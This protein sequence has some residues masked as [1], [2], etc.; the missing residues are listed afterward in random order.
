[1]TFYRKHAALF[2]TQGAWNA[3]LL[4]HYRLYHQSILCLKMVTNQPFRIRKIRKK[5][6]KLCGWGKMV[7]LMSWILS[8]RTW[9]WNHSFGMLHRLGGGGVDMYLCFQSCKKTFRKDKPWASIV[10]AE[11]ITCQSKQVTL[12]W[13]QLALRENIDLISRHL[14]HMILTLFG[15]SKHL[16]RSNGG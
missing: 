8:H 3:F 15:S 7:A 11:K 12:F 2:F 16:N 4:L 14:G 10:L 5:I 9:S 1:M 13:W 6:K